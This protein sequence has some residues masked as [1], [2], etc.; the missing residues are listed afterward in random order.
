MRSAAALGALQGALSVCREEDGTDEVRATAL[1][2]MHA[3]LG[4][5]R[6]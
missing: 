1:Q 6:R 3:A 4:P 2:V 5:D